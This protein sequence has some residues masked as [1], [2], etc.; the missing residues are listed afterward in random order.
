MPYPRFILNGLALV[1]LTVFWSL[2]AAI[3]VLLDRHGPMVGNVARIWAR[4]VLA[5]CG[6]KLEV[7]G[8]DQKLDAPA[9][10]VMANHTSHFD[11]I[12]LFA[13]VPISLRPVAKRELG[14]IPIFGWVLVIGAAIMID[15]GDRARAIAS[16]ERAGRAI[17]K[18]RSVLMFP[19]GTRTPPGELGPLKKGPFH[20]ALSAKVPVLPIALYGTGR[21][22][23]RGDW[24]IHPGRV[25]MV[26]GAPLETA[27]RDD[28]EPE[29]EA[30]LEDVK[31]E[32]SQLMAR[33]ASEA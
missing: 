32:L 17:R 15:R 11:V 30:L 16:I 8:L 5:V 26:I 14:Y 29:R 9:Y 21:V 19:E 13:G 22:L 7:H 20:L 25:V 6:V 24:R 33:A 3:A 18:G 28:S 1:V 31:R 2:V 12:S 4:S 10:L 27:G 23:M